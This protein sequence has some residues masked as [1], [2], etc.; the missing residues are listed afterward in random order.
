MN[1]RFKLAIGNGQLAKVPILLNRYLVICNSQFAIPK[2]NFH[3]P[4]IS[5]LQFACPAS[6]RGSPSAISAARWQARPNDVQSGGHNWNK[7]FL[8]PACLR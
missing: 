6:D 4:T 1:F 5:N 3:A 8:Q 7:G 2:L